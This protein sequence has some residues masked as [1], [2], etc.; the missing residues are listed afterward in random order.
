VVVAAALGIGAGEA[1]AQ[2]CAI[3]DDVAAEVYL[4]YV[5][6]LGE[7]FP[8]PEPACERVTKGAT[9]TCH[10][11]VSAAARCWKGVERG[12]RKGARTTCQEQGASEQACF[13]FT[14]G[15]LENLQSNVEASAA[16]GH[17]ACD[18]GAEAF[19]S[20]CLLGLF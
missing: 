15:E 8:M 4:A 19:R 7:G 11:T 9:S 18:A 2:A 13:D 12:L 5:E 14:A 3:P 1:R 17:A 10:R 6:L 20:A 16:E